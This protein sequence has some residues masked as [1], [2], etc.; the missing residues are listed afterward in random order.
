MATNILTTS[1]NLVKYTKAG[2]LK[3]LTESQIRSFGDGN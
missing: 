1:L 2:Y 3:Q